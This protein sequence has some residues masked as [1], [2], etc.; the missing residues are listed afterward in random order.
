MIGVGR[1]KR[2][3]PV[4]PF[5]VRH[6]REVVEF[7]PWTVTEG[8]SIITMETEGDFAEW[9]YRLLREVKLKGRT[10][11]SRTEIQNL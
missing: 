1:V 3:S 6:N 5:D 11:E 10:V 2:T 8:A 4:E 9:R 7:L